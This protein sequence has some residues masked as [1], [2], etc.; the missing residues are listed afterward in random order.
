MVVVVDAELDPEVEIEPVDELDATE[1]VETEP[2]VE[3]LAPLPLV[4]PAVDVSVAFPV[5]P[6]PSDTRLHAAQKQVP[7]T[8][9]RTRMWP[10]LPPWRQLVPTR[11]YFAVC[12]V[13]HGDQVF[14]QIWTRSCSWHGSKRR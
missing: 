4:L 7:R 12:G 9:T 3:E 14:Q 8:R 2:D 6:V 10:I 11:N 13:D 5:E 1:E